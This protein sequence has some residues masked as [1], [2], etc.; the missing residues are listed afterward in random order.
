LS[1]FSH[2]FTSSIKYKEELT[3]LGFSA[4][5]GLSFKDLGGLRN[6][7]TTGFIYF[8][9]PTVETWQ[10]GGTTYFYIGSLFINVIT[11]QSDLAMDACKASGT[12]SVKLMVR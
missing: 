2:K 1:S 8:G 3:G 10:S 5:G 12:G 4:N 9:D 6:N 7:C 11:G